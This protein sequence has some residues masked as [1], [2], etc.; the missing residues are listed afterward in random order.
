M[1]GTRSAEGLL[2]REGPRVLL[3]SLLAAASA[4]LLMSGPA[5][6][7]STLTV[8][9][10]GSGDHT[11]IG[12]AIEAAVDG[13]TI[14]IAPGEYV[15]NLHIDKDLTL[16]GDGDRA[17]VVIAGDPGDPNPVSIDG[18][19]WPVTVHLD[20]ADVV[21][22]GLTVQEVEGDSL[23]V[24]ANGGTQDLRDIVTGLIGVRGEASTSIVDSD[25]TRITI[26]GPI[27]TTVRDNTVRNMLF[28]G[29]GASGRITGNTVLDHPIVIDSGAS[30]DII[31][32][33]IRP[34]PNE[35]GITV[36]QAGTSATVRDN[37]IEGGRIGIHVEVAS[38]LVEGNRV[39]GNGE[40]GILVKQAPTIVRDNTVTDAA[41]VSVGVVG[42]GHVVEGNTVSGGRI[43]LLVG[44]PDIYPDEIQ[45]D[46]E[47][48]IV[49]NE[50]VGASH[51]GVLIHDTIELSGNTIC[52]GREPIV[53][54][55]GQPRIGPND[56]CEVEAG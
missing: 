36:E 33:T 42:D 1:G 43:G 56:I 40:I 29:N 35:L 48:R 2:T 17:E 8:A 24:I 13:D 4:L 10:D 49:D 50:I 18:D 16:A 3:V 53:V 25:V 22:Q 26:R 34:I 20:D 51:F 31:G 38:A 9:T 30:V 45:L 19:R 15:E 54:E 52:A 5:S 21:L 37:D 55:D 6:G 14:R 39:R 27:E 28:V 47:P 7:A 23:S 12:A 46:E 11:T 44:V 32:N 41:D